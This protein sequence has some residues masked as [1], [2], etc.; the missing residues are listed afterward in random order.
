MFDY[1]ASG[2]VR[3]AILSAG[4]VV[5]ASAATAQQPQPSATAM[6]TARELIDR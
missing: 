4:I 3:A 2:L 6:T 5:C 1:S